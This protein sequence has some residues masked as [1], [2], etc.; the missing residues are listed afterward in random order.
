MT[1]LDIIRWVLAGLL[2]AVWLLIAAGNLM[3][4]IGATIRK[5]STSFG[6]FIGG[7]AGA[8][9]LLIC[10]LSGTGRW[11]W[12]PVLLDIGCIPAAVAML[13]GCIAERRSKTPGEIV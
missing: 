4:V 9:S 1:I 3:S 12:L 13:Y 5:G 10:P 11:V 7:I 2:A 8:V 6:L